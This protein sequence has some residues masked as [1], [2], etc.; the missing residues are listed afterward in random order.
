MV[1]ADGHAPVKEWRVEYEKGG[2]WHE[3]AKGSTIGQ[4]L[5]VKLPEPVTAQKF[6]LSLKAD[7]RTAIRGWQM[8]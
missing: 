3:A 6:R 8:F 2:T 7:N 5:E 4:N 1:L